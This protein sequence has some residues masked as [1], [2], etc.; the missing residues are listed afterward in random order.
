MSYLDLLPAD[1]RTALLEGYREKN[2]N[3]DEI[4]FFLYD[5][6]FGVNNK[7]YFNEGKRKVASLNSIFSSSRLNSKFYIEPINEDEVNIIMKPDPTDVISDR[8]I[9]QILSL[10]KKCKDMNS[11]NK[12][13]TEKKSK[14]RIVKT[15]G[16]G[17][18]ECSIQIVRN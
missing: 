17:E 8:V 10:V 2:K 14:Y 4:F 11:I 12:V 18:S 16:I 3:N 1:M 5:Y 7:H 9:L 13:L 6:Y 15:E